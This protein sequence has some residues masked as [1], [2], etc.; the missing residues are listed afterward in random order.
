MAAVSTAGVS[1]AV[2]VVVVSSTAAGSSV[3]AASV[4]ACGPQAA[5]AKVRVAARTAA[6]V[7]LVLVMTVPQSG[8]TITD[9]REH[10]ITGL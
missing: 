5:T 6:R 3:E 2:S 8:G 4:L 10:R 1:V 7:S 9:A